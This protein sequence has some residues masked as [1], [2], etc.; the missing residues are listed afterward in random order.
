M[1]SANEKEYRNSIAIISII[2]RRNE[3]DRKQYI[4]RYQD[5]WSVFAGKISVLDDYYLHITEE[6]LIMPIHLFKFILKLSLNLFIIGKVL[7]T[8][9]LCLILE[10]WLFAMKICFFLE[11]DLLSPF[12]KVNIISKKMFV[13]IECFAGTKIFPKSDNKMKY[14]WV[15]YFE[16]FLKNIWLMY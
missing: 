14:S 16:D 3:H 1:K 6:T 10:W 5:F 7:L 9:N 11:R 4:I 13:F 12:C 15:S 8:C 2:C